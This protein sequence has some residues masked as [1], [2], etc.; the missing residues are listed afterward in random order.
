MLSLPF[1]GIFAFF[2]GIS[3]GQDTASCPVQRY[4]PW[5][6]NNGNCQVRTWN[7]EDCPKPIGMSTQSLRNQPSPKHGLRAWSDTPLLA[8]PLLKSPL[9]SI[10]IANITLSPPTAQECTNDKNCRDGS[11]CVNGLCCQASGLPQGANSCLT[12]SE[13]QA[14]GFSR[15]PIGGYGVWKPAAVT[16]PENMWCGCGFATRRKRY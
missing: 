10:N 12:A 2:T 6:G 16:V 3:L 5:S 4:C 9:R 15:T 8:L 14:C 11:Q 13:L 1:I 7:C